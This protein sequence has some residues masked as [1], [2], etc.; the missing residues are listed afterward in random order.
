MSELMFRLP[1]KSPSMLSIHPDTLTSTIEQIAHQLEEN[2]MQIRHL[3]VLSPHLNDDPEDD[4]GSISWIYNSLLLS[5]P[6][7]GLTA[8]DIKTKEQMF[9]ETAIDMGLSNIGVVKSNPITD[10]IVPLS[11]LKR[12]LRVDPAVSL[13]DAAKYLLDK[14]DE[15]SHIQQRQTEITQRQKRKRVQLPASQQETVVVQDTPPRVTRAREMA[16]MMTMSQPERG[17]HGVRNLRPRTTRRSG[18]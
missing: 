4:P 8:N 7:S 15:T 11:H 6:S 3:N 9:R 18:F 13:S 14:W 16:Q 10:D 12:F 5:L 1:Q 17:R 2:G